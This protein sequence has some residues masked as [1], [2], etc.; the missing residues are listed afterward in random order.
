MT[1]LTPAVSQPTIAVSEYTV[2]ALPAEARTADWWHWNVYARRNRSG[3]WIVTDHDAF[4][5]AAGGRHFTARA[6]GDF[7]RADAID[8]ATRVASTMTLMG[9]TAAQAAARILG[10]ATPRTEDI[11]FDRWYA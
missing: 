4:F 11:E 3:R 5:D 6:A 1:D 7:D 2:N 9:E 10:A 8:L